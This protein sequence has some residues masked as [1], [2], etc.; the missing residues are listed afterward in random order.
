MTTT[1]HDLTAGLLGGLADG[2][3]SAAMLAMEQR[4]GTPS[5]LV[6]LERKTTLKLGAPH[7][8]GQPAGAGEQAISHGSHL[9][10]STAAGAARVPLRRATGLSGVPAGLL[11]GLGFYLLTWGVAGPAKVGQTLAIHALFGVV[12]TLVADRILGRR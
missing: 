5:E 2:V 4:S 10:L 6:K 11:F 8:R 12:T 7:R 9:L 1:T 3:V